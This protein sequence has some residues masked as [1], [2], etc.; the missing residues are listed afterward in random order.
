MDDVL[1]LIISDSSLIFIIDDDII[2]DLS[3]RGPKPSVPSNKACMVDPLWLA[4]DAR[5]VIKLNA[6]STL[7]PLE[8]DIQ[9]KFIRPSHAIVLP[10]LRVREFKWKPDP[11]TFVHRWLEC[12]RLVVNGSQD[13]RVLG[14][15]YAHTP[16]RTLF[17]LVVSADR[18]LFRSDQ[19]L[20]RGCWFR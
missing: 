19:D 1:A 12:V 6:E 9:G 14:D 5:E 7:L 16:D 8:K 20:S 15:F 11:L 18:T 4:A 2:T 13:L 3:I 10:L 17:L